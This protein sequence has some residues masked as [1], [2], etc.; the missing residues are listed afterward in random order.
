MAD[1]AS[2]ASPPLTSCCAVWFVTGWDRYGSAG[3]GLGTPGV[4]SHNLLS[5]SII[6]IVPLLSFDLSF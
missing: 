6:R 4:A 2:L 1:E 5:H 3:L